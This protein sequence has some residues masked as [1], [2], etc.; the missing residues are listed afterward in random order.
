MVLLGTKTYGQ[1]G[2]EIMATWEELTFAL[3]YDRALCRKNVRPI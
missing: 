1:K 3:R 2:M